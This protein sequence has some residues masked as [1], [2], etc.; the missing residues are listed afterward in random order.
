MEIKQ[1]EVV[2]ILTGHK[3]QCGTDERSMA[4]KARYIFGRD[5]ARQVQLERICVEPA[6]LDPCLET[7]RGALTSYL[8][9]KW[10]KPVDKTGCITVVA[11]LDDNDTWMFLTGSAKHDKP[12][13]KPKRRASGDE[14][15]AL[16]GN[17]K[18]V[19]EGDM[20][21][22]LMDDGEPDMTRAQAKAAARVRYG[23]DFHVIKDHLQSSPEQ[24][25]EAE[26]DYQNHI[27]VLKTP[28]T[29]P[30]VIIKKMEAS[31]RFAHRLSTYYQYKIGT[32]KHWALDFSVF[33]MYVE[34]D[35]WNDCLKK[36]KVKSDDKKRKRLWGVSGDGTFHDKSKGD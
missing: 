24:R 27:E 18:V 5:R 32:R 12:G 22:E 15:N 31:M 17:S 33:T 28:G 23:K 29:L 25:L 10:P 9:N 3:I 8:Q 14:T 7:L 1:L 6:N 4:A 34:G 36:L 16:A 21:M 19:N 35:S 20:A 13:C 30:P 26:L 11:R 2:V